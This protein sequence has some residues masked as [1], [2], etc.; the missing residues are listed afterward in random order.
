MLLPPVAHSDFINTKTPN[1]DSH[2]PPHTPRSLTGCITGISVY[3]PQ[4]NERR[5]EKLATD[6]AARKKLPFEVKKKRKHAHAT[7]CRN[8]CKL[9]FDEPA[10]ENGTSQEEMR[11][12]E[13]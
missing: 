1:S 2:A 3:H 12:R 9:S 5:A 6:N 4:Q 7:H 10:R 8:R 13:V 11:S